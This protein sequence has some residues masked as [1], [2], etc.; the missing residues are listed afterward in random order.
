MVLKTLISCCILLGVVDESSQPPCAIV[1]TDVRE[2]A[3][4]DFEHYGERHRWC[5][6]GPQV[7]GIATN[8]EI[9]EGLF[10]NPYEFANRHL[11]RMNGSGA[12]WI[13]VENDGD[14]DLYLVNGAGG[15][16][17]TNALYLNLGDGTFEPALK[18]CGVLDDGEGMAVSV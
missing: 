11:V 15:P 8:E 5:E 1:L 10:E 4:I 13:D 2:A 6:I 7:E 16:E 17:T 18:V 3:G 12:A 14:Y 9:P